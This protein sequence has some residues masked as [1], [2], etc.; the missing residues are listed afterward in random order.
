MGF[1]DVMSCSPF[2]RTG[3]VGSWQGRNQI[4]THDNCHPNQ[5]PRTYSGS[6]IHFH[7]FIS[8][9]P[10]FTKAFRKFLKHCSWDEG[11]VII[12]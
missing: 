7:S 3:L 6:M 5:G 4:D 8:V 12:V 1:A 2:E 9:L 11:I 10:L